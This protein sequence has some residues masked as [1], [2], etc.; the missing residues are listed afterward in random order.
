MFPLTGE[1]E[2]SNAYQRGICRDCGAKIE[3]LGPS[4]R[5]STCDEKYLMYR[6][7]GYGTDT[8]VVN[9]VRNQNLGNCPFCGGALDSDTICSDCE[10][11]SS[12]SKWRRSQHMKGKAR[13]SGDANP[14]RGVWDESD[15]YPQYIFTPT[16]GELAKRIMDKA[17]Y[18]LNMAQRGGPQG[19]AHLQD[20]A[21]YARIAKKMQE[22]DKRTKEL[23]R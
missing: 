10:N 17:R 1:L 23:S 20:A 21:S 19:R 4:S 11:S 5:C 8:H 15:V 13:T 3:P 6:A 18:H 12:Q 22:Q 16:Y 2:K 7:S 14:Y 9:R